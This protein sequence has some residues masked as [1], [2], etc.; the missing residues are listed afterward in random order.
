M[1]QRKIEFID[2]QAQQRRIRDRIDARIRKVLD[3]GHYIMGPEV[4]ELEQKL[5]QF[6]GA[7]H[8]I[9]CSSGTDALLM[10]LMAQGVG[11]GDAVFTTPF[12]F[13][14]TAEVISLLG[15]TPFF[16]DIDPHTFSMDPAILARTLKGWVRSGYRLRPKGVIAVDVFGQPSDYD[17]IR[18]IAK[19]N[20]LFLLQDASQSFGATYH[21]KRVGTLADVTATSFFPA[22]P[23]GCYG[24][25][26]AMFCDDDSLAEL[27]RSIRAHGKG[28]DKYD[29]VRLG[30]NGRLD[31]I[32]AAI[33]LVKLEIFED[34]IRA[35]DRIASR[36]S[37]ALSQATGSKL[38]IPTLAPGRTSV[39]AQYS[40]LCESRLA[41]DRLAEG[42][43]KR[44]VPT[45]IYYPKP[46]HLQG[47]YRALG[48]S[49]GAFPRSESVSDRV[50]SLPMYPD[51]DEGTQDFII[52]E[53]L[54]ELG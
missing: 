13:A 21:G 24:D 46:L 30:I 25:G 42:L 44:G 17:E 33:L 15:A 37:R 45:A 43:K 16:I 2:L 34:E 47:A 14:A 8:C 4:E 1:T 50:L 39:W 51:L 26:G 38:Q 29:N 28:S 36:Y 18:A 32:Q 49:A 31:T 20:E 41:R 7:R 48:H 22:K 23:L 53:V 52:Q 27:F 6:T 9:S 40:V 19:A 10:P 3:H 11:P 35:R 12:S 5:A 54:K